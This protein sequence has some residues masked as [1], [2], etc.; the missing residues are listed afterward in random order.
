MTTAEVADRVG[1]Y[2]SRFEALEPAWSANGSSWALPLRRAG[3]EAFARTGIPTP[4]HEEWKYTDVREVGKLPLVHA[5]AAE[6]PSSAALESGIESLLGSLRLDPANGGVAGRLVLVDGRVSVR[7]SRLGSLAGVIEAH[8]LAEAMAALRSDV[9]PLLATVANP[10]AL[11]FVAL[12]TAF[13]QDGAFVRV[14]GRSDEP[15]TLHLLHVSTGAGGA[16]AAHP[17]NLIVLEESAQLRIVEDYA[18]VGRPEFLTNPV[19]EVVVGANARIEHYKI[20]R[21]AT[22]VFHLAGTTIR[23]ARDARIHA[24]NLSCGGRVV[25]NDLRVELAGEGGECILNGLNVAGER[26]LMDDHTVIVHEVPHCASR[27]YYRSVLAD[28]SQG[29]FNGKVFVRPGAQK[30]DGIQSNNALVL[31]P[32]ALMNTKPQLEIFADDVRCTHGATIGQL[33][34]DALFYLRSR[35]IRVNDARG[36]LVHAFAADVVERMEWAPVRALATAVLD[37]ALGQ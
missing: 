21:E 24:H 2:A 29:V 18:S 23:L 30:T 34:A 10:E 5:P 4:K 8:P 19:T 33:D 31:S 7:H 26:Q 27:E 37:R 35:G 16:A 17:R 28:E 1:P 12:N 15:A 13:F 36:I 3:L 6:V 32:K 22:T 25:R 9:E 20:V 14:R 11:P